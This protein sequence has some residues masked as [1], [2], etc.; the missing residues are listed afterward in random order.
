MVLSP[1]FPRRAPARTA[2]VSEHP[3]GSPQVVEA[4]RAQVV[5][6][7]RAERFPVVAVEER[8]RRRPYRLPPRQPRQTR[9]STSPRPVD[10]V[11]LPASCVR[12]WRHSSYSQAVCGGSRGPV[13]ETLSVSKVFGLQHLMPRSPC[14]CQQAPSTHRPARRLVSIGRLAKIRGRHPR[15]CRRYPPPLRGAACCTSRRPRR[16]RPLDCSRRST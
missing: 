1:P 15:P 10:L 8:C 6:P 14:P 16:S 12:C 4:V 5:H 9:T 13:K 3:S 11:E 2:A 7:S